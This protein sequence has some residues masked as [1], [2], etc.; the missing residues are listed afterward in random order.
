MINGE[1]RNGN[2]SLS[3]EEDIN[4]AVSKFGFTIQFPPI[5]KILAIKENQALPADYKQ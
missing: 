5:K 2:S 4:L 1:Y 3:S